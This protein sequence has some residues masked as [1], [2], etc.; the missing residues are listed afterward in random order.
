M[1]T[2]WFVFLRADHV[3]VNQPAVVDWLP[4]PPNGQIRPG[5]TIVATCQYNPDYHYSTQTYFNLHVGAGPNN[6][7]QQILAQLMAQ[8]GSTNRLLNITEA[9]TPQPSDYCVSAV[10]KSKEFKLNEG[11]KNLVYSW[12]FVY[13]P[14]SAA[15]SSWG[16]AFIFG[17]PHQNTT[18]CM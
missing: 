9:A 13:Q 18:S 6:D 16:L 8:Q 3:N 2:T 10:S 4:S 14:G 12:S 11:T 17:D 15:D 1:S 5:D 7:L